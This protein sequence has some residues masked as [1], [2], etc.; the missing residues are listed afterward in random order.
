VDKEQLDKQCEILNKL[1]KKYQS[2]RAFSNFIHEDASDVTRWRYGRNAI[3]PRAV[4]SICRYYGIEPYKL[5]PDIFPEDI[6]LVFN[7]VPRES[8][9]GQ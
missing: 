8:V 6:I 5:R 9:I 3:S 2:L 7:Y 4:I 1:I